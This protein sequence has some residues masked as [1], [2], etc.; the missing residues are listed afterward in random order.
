MN[1]T[2]IASPT[3]S[4]QELA[5]EI[6]QSFQEI[7]VTQPSWDEAVERLGGPI[8]MTFDWV[9]IWWSFYGGNNRLRIF[10]FRA[11]GKIVG[12]V[13]LFVQRI[14]IP[15][16]QMRVAKLIGAGIP[17]KV[18]NPP[19]AEEQAPEAWARI[20]QELFVKDQCHLIAIG[21][22]GEEY[23]AAASLVKL[24]HDKPIIGRTEKVQ[25]DVHTIY[26]LP[27]TF[28]AYFESIES[29]ERKIRKKKLRDLEAMGIVATEVA[30]EAADVVKEFERFAQAHTEQWNAEG[31]PG[32]FCAWPQGLDYN[33]DLVETHGKLD[34]VRFYKLLVDGKVVANQYTFA[35]G[36][37]LF[38]E[39]PSRLNGG[40]WQKL[41]LGGSS[42]IK[43]IEAAIEERFAVLESGLG[44]YEYKTLTGGIEL[45]VYVYYIHRAGIFS[46]IVVAINRGL[47]SLV[48]L[49]LHKIWYRKIMPKLPERFR[50]GQ[51]RLV[52]QWDL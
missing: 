5:V 42:Q 25:R 24:G 29:K 45:P 11:E 36:L 33:R 40:E 20:A 38:A 26:H 1:A 35:F 44:H 43:L 13:P 16:L 39:L 2:L 19:L 49:A 3:S 18:F 32:H 6:F 17:P 31:R 22:L 52:A 9:R 47:V 12:I 15:P 10:V 8:Y 46:K 51:P 48:R 23:K 28:D 37:T 27:D 7:R 50:G 14:G 34:R 41:G 30:F 4:R 21:P